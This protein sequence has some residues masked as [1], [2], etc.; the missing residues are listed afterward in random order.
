MCTYGRY[1]SRP[2]EP[3]LCLSAAGFLTLSPR[4][5]THTNPALSTCS[6]WTYQHVGD[7]HRG[8]PGEAPLLLPHFLHVDHMCLSF[9]SVV[10][11]AMDGKY[12]GEKTTTSVPSTCGLH[13]VR[14]CVISVTTAQTEHYPQDTYTVTQ[15]L[16]STEGGCRLCANPRCLPVD[17]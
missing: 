5:P 10:Q 1:P 14:H 17:L 6:A 12:S 2:S 16:T 7:I 13:T 9:V 15:R 3:A 4:V 8:L 11:P